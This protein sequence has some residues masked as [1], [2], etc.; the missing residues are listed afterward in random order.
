MTRR[1]GGGGGHNDGYAITDAD[2]ADG[3]DNGMIKVKVF[4]V[5]TLC[6]VVGYQ[7]FRG[8]RS[9]DI[10]TSTLR[11]R[12]EMIFEMLVFS[13]FN[14]LNQVIAQENFII[15]SCQESIRSYI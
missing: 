6:S 9:M 1:C 10:H 11:T 3:D 12:T 15:L 5:V 8:P 13:P 7:Y 2:Y 14:H 4:W